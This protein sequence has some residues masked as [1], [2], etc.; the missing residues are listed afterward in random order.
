MTE[1][2]SIVHYDVNINDDENTNSTHVKNEDV[3]NDYDVNADVNAC[4]R[5]V[6]WVMSTMMLTLMSTVQRTDVNACVPGWSCERCL[7]SCERA[8]VNNDDA[9]NTDVNSATHVVSGV[10]ND[11]VNACPRMVLWASECQGSVF[12]PG[13]E[14]PAE[15]EKDF[16]PPPPY[17]IS[18]WMLDLTF[19]GEK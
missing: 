19:N 1:N 2:M 13:A 16:H 8:N 17:K 9:V 7:V 18:C 6:L 4:L 14:A 11:D 5:R 10:N 15:G 12:T 3:N